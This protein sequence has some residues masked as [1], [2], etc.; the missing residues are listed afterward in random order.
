MALCRNPHWQAGQGGR[1]R[2]GNLNYF[3]SHFFR[4]AAAAAA[5][6]VQLQ[7]QRDV[8]PPFPNC[9]I[10]N[11]PSFWQT[12]AKSTL[13]PFPPPPGGGDREERGK[14]A[15]SFSPSF[16]VM[17]ISALGE[18]EKERERRVLWRAISAPRFPIDNWRKKFRLKKNHRDAFN[19]W[20]TKTC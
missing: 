8:C 1:T 16:A 19:I 7:V 3:F 13:S 15:S 6:S 14:E 4:T 18:R 2:E 17:A 20:A 12:A 11:G 10:F 5:A 9:N